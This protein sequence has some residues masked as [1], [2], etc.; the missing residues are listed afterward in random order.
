MDMG[1][2]TN[3]GPDTPQGFGLGPGTTGPGMANR[4]RGSQVITPQ[5]LDGYRPGIDPEIMYFRNP[6]PE[7]LEA[8]R[9]NVDTSAIAGKH[10]KQSIHSGSG[11]GSRPKT[12]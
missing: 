4:L 10:G 1:G 5:E 12:C 7:E 8:A 9:V 3:F 6:T 2:D 11:G